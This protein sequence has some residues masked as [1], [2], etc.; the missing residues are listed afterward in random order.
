MTTICEDKQRLIN[1]VKSIATDLEGGMT[2]EQC[3]MDHEEFNSEPSDQIS[4]LDYLQDCLDMQYI[5][6]GEGEFLGARILVAFGGPNIW[7]DTMRCTVDGNWW[8]DQH[9][10]GYGF[11][12]MGIEDACRELWECK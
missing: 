1:H 8:G 6:N 12:A 7:I 11:D 4:G 10:E 2:F 3:G 9:S 5:V